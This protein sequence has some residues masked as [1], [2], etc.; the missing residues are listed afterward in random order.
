MIQIE[1]QI[2]SLDII[3]K[4]FT[5]DLN[6]C[7]GACC[8]EGDSGAPIL[9]KERIFLEEN[10]HK[11]RPYMRKKAID[12]VKKKGLSVVDSEGDLTT[13]LV[14]DREC[15]FVSIEEGINKCSVEQAYLNGKTNFKKPISCHLFPIRITK[16]KNFEA[17]NYEKIPICKKAC[18]CGDKLKTPLYIFLK[19]AL[20]RKYGEKWYKKLITEI[21]K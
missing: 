4:N 13:N 18:V 12:V 14:N 5:C 19:E 16:H 11:I 1:D 17:L 15:V 7:K 3:E 2:L 20:I 8:V 6:S 9:D 10:Y 21:N